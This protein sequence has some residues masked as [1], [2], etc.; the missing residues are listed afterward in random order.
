MSNLLGRV[1]RYLVEGYQYGTDPMKTANSGSVMRNFHRSLSYQAGGSPTAD[2]AYY[3]R[4]ALCNPFVLSSVQLIINRLQGEDL[5]VVEELCEGKWKVANDHPIP[6]RLASPNAIMPGSLINADTAAWY[7]L[8][9]NGYWLMRTQIPGRGPI[10]EIWPVPADLIYPEPSTLR[11]SPITGRIVVDYR[12]SLTGDLLPGENVIHFRTWNPLP[13][14]YWQGLSP[15]SALTENLSTHAE[16]KGW[17]K[18]FF[19]PGN[20]V[21][22]AVISVPPTLDDQ[23]FDAVVASIEEQFG[24]GRRTAVIRSGDMDVKTIQQTITEMEIVPSF[25]WDQKEVEAVYGI[26]EGL[27]QGVSGVALWAAEAALA[28]NVIQPILNN[29][30]NFLSLKIVPMYGDPASLRIVAKNVIPTDETIATAKFNTYSPVRTI[31]ENRQELGLEPLAYTGSLSTLQPL[32]DQVPVGQIQLI[33]PV[34]IQALSA[35]APALPADQNML[36]IIS[37]IVGLNR[38]QPS[39]PPAYQIDATPTPQI[40]LDRLLGADGLPATGKALSAEEMIAML[41]AALQNADNTRG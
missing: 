14:G 18:S 29:F 2:A 20:A 26:P 24:G 30:A 15:L 35:Q 32:L 7:L 22:T 6:K 19:G 37:E 4:L 40:S 3:M 34:L 28:T 21:P 12:Y 8:G 23:T 1:V 25:A 9:G 5:F 31:K 36:S 17:L 13:N 41:Y 10:Q 16:K 39:M 27:R 11:Q 33:A 38:T